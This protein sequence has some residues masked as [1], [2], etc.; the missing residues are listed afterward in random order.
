MSD[1]LASVGARSP[2]AVLSAFVA[3]GA[4]LK[5]WAGGAPIQ[6]DNFAR[7]EFSGPRS[8]FGAERADN[9][10]ALQELA[11]ASPR[12]L[13]VT[14]AVAE[15]SAED[16][17][18]VADMLYR[19]DGY[20]PALNLF[21]RIVERSPRDRRA[22]DG[23]IRAAVPLGRAPYARDVLAAAADPVNDEAKLALSQL[24]ASEGAFE[25]SARIP[26]GMVQSQ[27]ANLPAVEQ[28]ASIFSDAGD[29][30]H[31]A[32]AVA[33]LRAQA[34]D[35]AS[36]RYYSA[37]L[38]YMQQR[39]DIAIR[40]AEAA[41]AINPAY[42]RAQNVL[43]AALAGVSHAIGRTPR[44]YRPSASIRGTPPPT[45]TSPRS[46]WKPVTSAPRDSLFAEALTLDPSKFTIPREGLTHALAP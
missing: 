8:V 36:T 43:G 19:A 28:L 45:P 44:S 3:D 7:L 29:A 30:E 12:P 39:P 41:L 25:D 33:R 20:A 26:L 15:A 9:A 40:E 32:P 38:A 17:R 42:A 22:L 18:D 46:K 31:L 23:L 37:T 4:S 5:A 16:W 10:R 21:V 24:L 11:A 6:T 27:P 2:L 13:A 35:R 14:Q 1:D 34:L